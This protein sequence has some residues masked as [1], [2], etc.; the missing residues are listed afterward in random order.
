M[1]AAVDWHYLLA[2]GGHDPRNELNIVHIWTPAC[3]QI[4]GTAEVT[5][6]NIGQ[7]YVRC[8]GP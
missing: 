1:V 8:T 3:N 7:V 5:S 6:T 4:K 2:S